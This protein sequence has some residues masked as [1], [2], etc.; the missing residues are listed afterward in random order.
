MFSL[1]WT[2]HT[3]VFEANIV[4]Q[5]KLNYKTVQTSVKGLGPFSVEQFFGHTEE[6][7]LLKFSRS[8][9]SFLLRPSLHL[10]LSYVPVN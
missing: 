3:S 4:L 1:T 7:H 10:P 8:A 9:F 5:R 2:K 6:L